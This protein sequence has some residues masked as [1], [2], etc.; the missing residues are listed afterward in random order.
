KST[1]DNKITYIEDGQVKYTTV[2][3]ESNLRSNKPGAGGCIDK[4]KEIHDENSPRYMQKGIYGKGSPGYVKIRPIIKEFDKEEI[5][6]AIEK[7]TRDLYDLE[8]MTDFSTK[9]LNVN[10]R[11]KVEEE[12][13]KELL[14]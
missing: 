11:E 1:E 13:K 7:V 4:N 8:A 5:N 12:I 14:R 3:C 10:I 2:N 9:D 6:D